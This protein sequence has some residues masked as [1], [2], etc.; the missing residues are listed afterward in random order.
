MYGIQSQSKTNPYSDAHILFFIDGHNL[1]NYTYIA[2]GFAGE[3]TYNQLLFSSGP[4]GD[5]A[6]TLLLQNG[7]VGGAASLLLLDY[8]IYET[9]VVRMV[10]R[11]LF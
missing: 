1:V 8:L 4:L 11:F 3:Y 10:A 9:Y 7:Y 5:G 6:H 2:P